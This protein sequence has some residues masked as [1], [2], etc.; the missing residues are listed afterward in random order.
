MRL[1]HS[2]AGYR[3]WGSLIN[4]LS[5]SCERLICEYITTVSSDTRTPEYVHACRFIY[6]L[7]QGSGA[8]PGL[9]SGIRGCVRVRAQLPPNWRII[10][11][12]ALEN[13]NGARVRNLLFVR[14]SYMHSEKC[15]LVLINCCY[16]TFSLALIKWKNTFLAAAQDTIPSLVWKPSQR[17]SWLTM[18]TRK[19]I[20]K[21]RRA[22]QRAKKTKLDR[23]WTRCWDIS[24]CVRQQTRKDHMSYVSLMFKA[25]L[26][27]S[28]WRCF[29]EQY[30]IDPTKSSDPDC[31]PGHLLKKGAPFI[32][33]SLADLFSR[34]ISEGKLPDDWKAAHIVPVCIKRR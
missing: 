8:R 6:G 12:L 5:L 10:L 24:N 2:Y 21:K 27:P 13:G 22:Y 19:P 26:F 17:K 4:E 20:K 23:H 31:I 1:T 16:A 29:R 30:R 18:D 9:G 3:L 25:I 34:S 14:Y 15:S 11:W 33:E 28:C 32:N 7:V